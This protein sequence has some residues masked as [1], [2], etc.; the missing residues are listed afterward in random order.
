MKAGWKLLLPALALLPLAAQGDTPLQ[1]VLA[2]PGT[3]AASSGAVDRF[4]LRFYEAMVS[5]GDPRAKPAAVLAKF[6][7]DRSIKEA[8]LSPYIQSNHRF[9]IGTMRVNLRLGVR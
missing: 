6:Q 5:L 8:T 1:V 3:G 2:A 7:A 9:D 4:T